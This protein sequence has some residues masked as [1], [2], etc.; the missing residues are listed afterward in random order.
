MRGWRHWTI[1]EKLLAPTWQQVR[2]NARLLPP[3]PTP[4]GST[5][6]RTVTAASRAH[7]KGPLATYLYGAS[8]WR[9]SLQQH[10]ET[11]QVTS[12]YDQWRSAQDSL[13]EEFDRLHPGRVWLRM[14][15]TE[16]SPVRADSPRWY[17][18]RQLSDK[19]PPYGQVKRVSY[20]SR[21]PPK[22][23]CV[24]CH[25]GQP[26]SWHWIEATPAFGPGR[27]GFQET[28]WQETVLFTTAGSCQGTIRWGSMHSI[29][30]AIQARL[31]E[32]N[33]TGGKPFRQQS[34]SDIHN[35]RPEDTVFEPS[36]RPIHPFG[37]DVYPSFSLSNDLDPAHPEPCNETAED[38]CD[39]D[40]DSAYSL[41]E[42]SDFSDAE[43]VAS[44]LA[45]QEHQ[46]LQR[47]WYSWRRLTEGN[48]RFDKGSDPFNRILFPE[49]SGNQWQTDLASI[50]RQ[51]N[52]PFGQPKRSTRTRSATFSYRESRR[53]HPLR[54]PMARSVVQPIVHQPRR[55]TR[56]PPAKCSTKRGRRQHRQEL[57]Q[58]RAN[59][60]ADRNE[61]SRPARSVVQP[62]S[63]FFFAPPTAPALTVYPAT[64][65]VFVFGAEARSTLTGIEFSPSPSSPATSTS[66]SSSSSSSLLLSHRTLTR[67][68]Q[69]LER[70][71]LWGGTQSALLVTGKRA[72]EKCVRDGSDTK[73]DT[74]AGQSP[75]LS[76]TARI[77]SQRPRQLHDVR[78]HVSLLHTS[79]LSALDDSSVDDSE[80]AASAA[81]TIPMLTTLLSFWLARRSDWPRHRGRKARDFR[82]GTAHGQLGH[83]FASGIESGEHH[84]QP[85]QHRSRCTRALMK[86]LGRSRWLNS[87]CRCLHSGCTDGT[88]PRPSI[89]P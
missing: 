82:R 36:P 51:P 28:E 87:L 1:Q 11:A 76:L 17:Q 41:T 3:L 46:L 40:F 25:Y 78:P 56:K 5:R 30:S 24:L 57:R 34:H 77:N 47:S 33:V 69:G 7:E 37:R 16:N 80:H 31:A 12:S 45:F 72:R 42:D 86:T 81:S 66:S 27:Y 52:S 21:P 23:R 9:T 8:P 10:E 50:V 6:P 44:R 54:R 79:D 35:W 73:I 71:Q 53:G 74:V 2:L 85:R 67:G 26:N 38:Y 20:C 65:G 75:S 19:Y 59:R 62:S 84:R 88:G 89:E 68:L 43:S 58:A 48:H 14:W 4:A 83:L 49:V 13:L 22:L 32:L 55:S 39:L 63:E 15:L 18:C 70:N 60:K 64:S 61:V 29:M